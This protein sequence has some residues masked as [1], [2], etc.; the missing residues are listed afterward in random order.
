[1]GYEYL[2]H[3][4]DV[5]VRAEGRTMEE[6]FESGAEAALNVMFDLSSIDETV[7]V[8]FAADAPEPALL[9]VETINE[10]L[11][12]QDRHGLALKRLVSG[13]IRKTD[14]GYRFVGTARGEP[15]DLNKH[16]VK[17]EVKAAT[18]SGL[19]YTESPDKEMRHAFE[20]VLDV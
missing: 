18:Y 9:F 8:S 16:A 14:D 3:A 12:I 7:T 13:E 19:S 20:C 10:V 17:T 1:M 2:E 11:S 6:A 5:G 4:A 15:L